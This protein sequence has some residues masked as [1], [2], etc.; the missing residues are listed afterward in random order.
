MIRG[1]RLSF[2]GTVKIHD[3]KHACFATGYITPFSTQSCKGFSKS[4]LVCVNLGGGGGL[5]C[6]WGWIPSPVEA[7]S[8]CYFYFCWGSHSGV[9]AMS[10]SSP[11][12][13]G[14][15]WQVHLVAFLIS[16]GHPVS[17]PWSASQP[18]SQT[19]PSQL[20]WGAPR[21]LWLPVKK[22]STNCKVSGKYET[23]HLG[24]SEG[25]MNMVFGMGVTAQKNHTRALYVCLYILLLCL[26]TRGIVLAVYCMSLLPITIQLGGCQHS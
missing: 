26:S 1:G 24:L 5:K 17:G 21:E 25:N 2:R 15:F 3:W 16:K 12:S 11:R 8:Y 14:L 18:V 4:G 19:N 20:N 7:P 23:K 22:S 13:L 10:E 9:N 6:W